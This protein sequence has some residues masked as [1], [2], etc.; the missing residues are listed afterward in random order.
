MLSIVVIMDSNELTLSLK[1]R[2]LMHWSDDPLAWAV[3]E[4]CLQGCQMVQNP[5]L[6]KFLRALE[7]ELLVS[8]YISWPFSIFCDTLV[9]S[10]FIRHIIPFWNVVPWQIWQ[11]ILCLHPLF[12]LRLLSTINKISMQSNAYSNRVEQRHLGFTRKAFIDKIFFCNV[13]SEPMGSEYIHAYI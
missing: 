3:S 13:Q 2:F 7:W 4:G 9:C 6:V 1:L 10:M 8:W 12:A 11:A 5:N